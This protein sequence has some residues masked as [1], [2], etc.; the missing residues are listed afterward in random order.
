[1]QPLT[2]ATPTV[3]PGSIKT[4]FL[5]TGI[6][7]SEAL[8]EH[9]KTRC[10]ELFIHKYLDHHHFTPSNLKKLKRHFDRTVSRCKVIITTEKDAMRLLEP[11]L[12]DHLGDAPVYFLPVSVEFHR[13]DRERFNRLV[14]D[15]LKKF[16]QKA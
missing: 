9:L 15:F 13:N 2:P 1:M 11:G 16:S 8:E 6:A 7:R 10:D 4:I 14:F 3:A 12:L 5:L